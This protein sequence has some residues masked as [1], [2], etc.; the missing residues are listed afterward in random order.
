MRTTIDVWA[1]RN[2]INAAALNELKVMLGLP[3][4]DA[5]NVPPSADPPGSEA[6]QQSLVRIEAAQRSIRLFRNN[7]G[8]FKDE[9]GRM[10]RY[11]LANE[12]KAANEILKSPDLIGWRRT[13]IQP[14]M[15]GTFIGQA[16]MREMKAEGWQYRGDAHER[17]Q[18]A[19]L[20]LALADGCDAAFATGPGTL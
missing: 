15:V 9:S 12:S 10:V 16:C 13:L 4:L 3:A 6:R 5:M 1:V 8:A 18:L 7:S 14:H 20:Q 17:A 2:N 11:G 19:F